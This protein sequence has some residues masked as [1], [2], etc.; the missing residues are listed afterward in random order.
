MKRIYLL[1]L[2]LSATLGYSQPVKL[3]Y[4]VE[5]D[6]LL[7]VKDQNGKI[8]VPARLYY[9][10][11]AY[12]GDTIEIKTAVFEMYF[13]DKPFHYYDRKG[14]Y[15]FDTYGTG[16]GPDQY[17]QGFIRYYENH[18]VGLANTNGEKVIAAHYDFLSSANFGF[19]TYC[20]GCK[21]KPSFDGD[22]HAPLVGGTWGY[23][24]LKGNEI[25]VLDKRSSPKDVET[26][27]HKFIPYQFKY[28]PKEQQILNYFKK[29]EQQLL[30]LYHLTALGGNASKL[31][32]EITE[33][34]TVYQPYY[35]ITTFRVTDN[36]VLG[37][38]YY[39][40][41]Q[42]FKVSADGKEFFAT[43]VELVDYK[44]HSIYIERKIPVE[45]WIKNNLKKN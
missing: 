13:K 16:E 9:D 30:A 33:R 17:S 10:T 37:S 20:N 42:N 8:I 28:T 26:E 43:Y 1:M 7:G 29:R 45:T 2:F 40:D 44:S 14:N 12:V 23:L 31:Y 24:D 21:R 19:T 6:S 22:E 18:K 36:Q 27:N 15:L 34:P 41:Y 5:S 35:V 39:D 11:S 32:F 25:Q 38:N 3:F 4:Y